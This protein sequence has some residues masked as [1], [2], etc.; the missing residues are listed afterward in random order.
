MDICNEVDKAMDEEKYEKLRS[1]ASGSSSS[2][3]HSDNKSEDFK[4]PPKVIFFYL[5]IHWYDMY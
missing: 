2:S 1:P 4:T 3:D 5:I